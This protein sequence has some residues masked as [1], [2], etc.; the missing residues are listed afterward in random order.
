MIKFC[1]VF[2]FPLWK[3]IHSQVEVKN[4][5]KKFTTGIKEVYSIKKC[6]SFD[7]KIKLTTALVHSRGH[8][9]TLLICTVLL[10]LMFS[11]GVKVMFKPDKLCF[12]LR[13][14]PS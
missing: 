13:L 1:E 14:E 8:F 6:S 5:L 11:L 12:I 10:S 9:I 2:R 3:E 4:V 7:T